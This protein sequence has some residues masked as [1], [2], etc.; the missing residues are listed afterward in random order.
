MVGAAVVSA[1]AALIFLAVDFYKTKDAFPPHSFIGKLPVSGLNR[2]QAIALIGKTPT[3][4]IFVPTV[5]FYIGQEVFTFPVEE[6]GIFVRAEETVDQAFTLTHKENY[7]KELRKRLQREF[8]ELPLILDL[9][10]ALAQGVLKELSGQINST[11]RD[12]TIDLNE[13][14]GGYH[15]NPD[16]PGRLL[17]PDKT[18]V[19]ARTALNQGKNLFPI[20]VDYYMLPRITEA[21]LRAAPPVYRLASFTTYYGKHDSPN[22]IHN[23]KLIASWLNNT[24]LLSGETFSLSEKIGDF[25]AARG[26]KEAYVIL[27][28]ELV[29]QLGG[30]TCQIATTLFNATALADLN[31]ISRRN[32]S[33]YFSIYPLGRDATVYPGQ[34]D[35][36]FGN[37]TGSPILI[38][39]LANNRRLSFTIYGTPTGKR[40]E[41]SPAEAY[42]LDQ[43]GTFRP[44]SLRRVIQTD[45]PFRTVLTRTVYDAQGNKIKEEVVRSFYKLYGDRSN[46]PVRRPEPR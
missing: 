31:I 27:G 20:E 37:N 8:I 45:R 13:V 2:E 46:V 44:S 42:I 24:L 36:K 14:S 22:R 16:S 7:L 40:V 5:S 15:I 9:D 3:S 43:D 17:N 34:A 21:D 26:F 4:Q 23:I 10:P 12:A 18:V 1:G 39:A 32:H 29:P 6:L 30:G 19:A 11:P 28:G 38:K 41:F 33:F 25:T 35:L